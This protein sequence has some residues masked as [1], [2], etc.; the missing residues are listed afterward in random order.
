M[1]I[2]FV[3]ENYYP[4]V[5]GVETLF[6]NLI[7]SLAEKGHQITIMTTRLD[8]SHPLKE[9]LPNI[10]IYRYP[11]RNRYAFTFLALFPMLKHISSVDLVHTTSYNAAFPAFIASKLRGKKVII[12]FHEVWGSLWYKLPFMSAFTRLGHSVFERVLLKFSFDKVVAV[13]ESTAEK[14]IEYGIRSKDIEIIHNGINYDEWKPIETKNPDKP[15]TYTYYG[16][17]G[18]SKGL[19]LLIKAA[20]I[21]RMNHPESRFKMIIPRV[22]EAL[23]K[24]VLS[25]IEQKELSSHIE[26]H[27]ELPK[28]K[29]IEEICSSDCVVIPSYS[30][31]FCFAA[32]ETSALNIP[33]VSSNQT[34]LKETVTGRHVK[35]K[36][37]TVP[38]L[39]NAVEAAMRGEWEYSEPKTF[40][41][42]ENTE[43][44]IQLYE[45]LENS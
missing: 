10:T 37:M 32:V 4:N 24:H 9:E 44:Y 39:V 2:L 22:P 3:L 13:S 17:L 35:M 30:E 6:K 11:F 42:E 15:F 16:R 14:L 36:D 8:P 21:I 5:G 20:D 41:L 38:G 33:I 29:L 19:N 18:I 34:A 28:D 45:Q 40:P 12:T 23:Y 31:G 43:K 25:L 27:H 1:K 26:M 7:E